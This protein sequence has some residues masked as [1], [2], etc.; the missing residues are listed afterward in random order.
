MFCRLPDFSYPRQNIPDLAHMLS[1]VKKTFVKILV[2]RGRRGQF[3]H[4]PKR[5]D[6]V[7]RAECELNNV[8]PQVWL[9]LEN[10]RLPW[11]LQP[12]E[13]V[14]VDARVRRIVYPHHCE[15]VGTTRI[16]FWRDTVCT[17]KMSQRLLA[18]LVVIPTCLRDYVPPV[19]R[20]ILKIVWGLRIL[21]GDVCSLNE[22]ERRG[23][24]PGCP[25]LE[26]TD[27]A[28]AHILIVTGLSMLEG[29]LPV[30]V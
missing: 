8:F 26:R 10:P 11:R 17:W 3:K 28:K 29:C 12:Q 18:L 25:C 7:H 27:I 4:Y 22:C 9:H 30:C 15:T 5:R 20:A 6:L 23:I 2:G 19:H 16:S 14:V 21:D 13:L 24:V 1:N